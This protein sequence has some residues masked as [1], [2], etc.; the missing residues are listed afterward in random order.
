MWEKSRKK[1]Q[2]ILAKQK[3]RKEAYVAKVLKERQEINQQIK[4]K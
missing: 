2:D 4:E 1:Q 3:A